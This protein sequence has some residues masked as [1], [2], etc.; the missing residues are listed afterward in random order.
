M[1]F[2]EFVLTAAG[3]LVIG[4]LLL[5]A[6]CLAALFYPVFMPACAPGDFCEAPVGAFFM[7]PLCAVVFVLPVALWVAAQQHQPAVRVDG[8]VMRLLV[9]CLVLPYAMVASIF[10][11]ARGGALAPVLTFVLPVALVGAALW[12]TFSGA[13][14]VRPSAAAHD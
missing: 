8:M 5:T 4:C 13:R 1:S 9:G 10:L 12:I 14:S 6:S 7:L 2:L 11:A 3:L